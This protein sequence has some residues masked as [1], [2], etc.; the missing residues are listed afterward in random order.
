MEH[1]GQKKKGAG[2]VRKRIRPCHTAERPSEKDEKR[3]RRKRP[4]RKKGNATTRRPSM[5]IICLPL[6]LV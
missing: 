6:E 4:E 5:V 2:P 3:Q 1:R